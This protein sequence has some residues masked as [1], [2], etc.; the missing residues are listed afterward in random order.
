MSYEVMKYELYILIYCVEYTSN[1][2]S[3]NG[4]LTLH[5]LTSPGVQ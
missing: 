5:I 1:L 4:S 3:I 2:R